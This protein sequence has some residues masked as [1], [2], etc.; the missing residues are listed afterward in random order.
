MRPNYS[1]KRLVVAMVMTA[2]ATTIMGCSVSVGNIGHGIKTE[3]HLGRNNFEVIKSVTGE[4][5]AQYLFG[6]FG[7]SKGN[8]LD[9]ARRDLVEKAKLVGTSNALI[10][11]TTDMRTEL[12]FPFVNKTAYVSGEVIR[13]KD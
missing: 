10:N 7:P 5:T 4:A 6:V 2:T 11:V 1:I 13:F 3:V 8:I 9:Q 12:D